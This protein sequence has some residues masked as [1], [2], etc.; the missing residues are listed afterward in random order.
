MATRPTIATKP[1]KPTHVYHLVDPRDR[2]VRYVGKTQTPARRLKEHVEESLLR[3][4]TRKKQ[5][6]HALHLAGLQPVIVTVATFPREHL[7]R[8]CESAECHKHAATIY[9]IHDPAKGAKD[10]AHQAPAKA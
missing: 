4:N 6:I 7:A 2:V 3:Q 5:W 10:L 9:N 1:P 8:D